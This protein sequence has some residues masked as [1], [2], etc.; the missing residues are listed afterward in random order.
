MTDFEIE[1]RDKLIAH[2]KLEDI[3][4]DTFTGDT[5][6]FGEGGLELDSIDAIEIEVMV[7]KEYGVD[8]LPSERSRSTFGSLGSL[9]GF[10][11]RRRSERA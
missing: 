7:Q 9:A 11:Q 3:D 1:L 8:I 10:I 2:L 4:P 6:L 5:P